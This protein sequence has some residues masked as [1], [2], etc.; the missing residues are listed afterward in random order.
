VTDRIAFEPGS[1]R[2]Q[3]GFV[4][5]VADTVYRNISY[6]Y[7]A[8]YE[9]LISSGLYD[10]LI[11]EGLLVSHEE[12]DINEYTTNADCYKIIKPQAIPFI[13]YPYEWCFEQLREAALLTL[14][15]QKIAF[16]H[17]MILKDASAY[18]IQYNGVQPILIDTLSFSRYQEGSPWPG[19]RQFCQHFLAVL[20]LM[21]F[22]DSRTSLLLKSFIDGI[23]LDL[24]ARLLPMKTRWRFSLLTHIHLQARSIKRHETGSK[25]AMRPPRISK[26]SFSALIDHLETSI[27][28][29]A[30]TSVTSEWA[31]YYDATNYSAAGIESKQKIV[32]AF[33]QDI[34]A[35]LAWDLGAN[36][37]KFSRIL[38]DKGIYTVSADLDH[39]AVQKNFLLARSQSS[40]NILPLVLDITNPTAAIGWRNAERKQWD[41]RKN[42]DLILAL[43]LIHHLCFS[44]N[45]GFDSI[46][47]YFKS[48]CK[49]LIVEFVPPDDSQ[50]ALLPKPNTQIA[51]DYSEHNFESVF[52]KYFDLEKK[53]TVEGSKR[54]IYL[55]KSK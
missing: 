39:E 13:S 44:H 16:D 23:P 11:A 2:D 20:A 7:K 29:L 19:Y 4:F 14:R 28:A 47:S 55:Y 53:T 49:A 10:K 40:I 38:S 41:K 36:N 12:V 3:S 21:K 54:Q 37:G 8:D 26:Y 25:I 31:D 24:A 18:N 42:P 27:K 17:G 45:I 22:T 5:Y 15:I 48:L 32:K 1:F 52:A 46:A 50:V 9:H 30:R 6:S 34:P 43:A 51:H 33:V 35:A